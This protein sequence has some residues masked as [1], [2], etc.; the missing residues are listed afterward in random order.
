[1]PHVEIKC[2]PGRT[3]EMKAKC[4]EAVS[5]AVAETM[6]CNESSVS[7]S[8]KEVEQTEWKPKVWDTQIQPEMETLYKKPGYTCE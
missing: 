3:E 7:I 6:G 4:A 2:F 5:K 8:I 1:M